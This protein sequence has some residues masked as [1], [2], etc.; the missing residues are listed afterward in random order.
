[1]ALAGTLRKRT[2]PG[3]Q[4]LEAQVRCLPALEKTRELLHLDAVGGVLVRQ[5]RFRH[6]EDRQAGGNVAERVDKVRGGHFD[7]PRALSPE[8]TSDR[9]V[10]AYNL[11]YQVISFTLDRAP[12]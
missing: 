2:T 4:S 9:R 3:T 10:R 12:R 6:P 5:E 7:D 1:V 8:H 11:L